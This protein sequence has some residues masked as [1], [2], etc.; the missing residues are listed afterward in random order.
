M[1][2]TPTVPTQP[3]AT[4]PI[5]K[6]FPVTLV[7]IAVVVLIGLANI[8]NLFSGKGKTGKQSA[9]STRPATIS[10]QQVKSYQ[11]M[12]ATE[13][14]HDAEDRQ[15]QFQAQQA[16][17]AYQSPDIPGP[18]ADAAAPMTAAQR[19]AI[20]GDSPNAPQ[21]TS[22]L[23]KGTPRQSSASSHARRND[24]TPSTATP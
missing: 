12:Q 23:R 17:A 7:L 14:K 8:S 11:S 1:P 16:A 13:V 19:Q 2:E 22:T 21:R 18:E 3:V 4:P 6:G 24:R 15:T 9:L 10:P 5:K 20:Y